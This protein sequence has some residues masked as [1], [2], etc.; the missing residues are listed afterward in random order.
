MTNNP[1]QQITLNIIPFTPPIT[2]GDFAFYLTKKEPHYC[3]IHKDDIKGMLEGVIAE[4][5]LEYGNWL[6]TDFKEPQE[7]AIILHIDL[8]EHPH[9]GS[10]YY[11]YLLAD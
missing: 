8:A 6:Y 11:R 9:F 10:H 4:E 5:E 7:D 3:P 1:P 2:S